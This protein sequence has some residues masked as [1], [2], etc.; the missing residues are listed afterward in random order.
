MCDGRN[1]AQAYDEER[2]SE[3]ENFDV[4]TKEDDHLT[5]T[6]R[7]DGGRERNALSNDEAKSQPRVRNAK[8]ERPAGT[9][10]T[11]GRECGIERDEP[12]PK[13]EPISN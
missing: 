7:V 6:A 12:V 3:R 1:E 8:G 13:G 2:N 5:D 10:L 11:E 4:L 9:G